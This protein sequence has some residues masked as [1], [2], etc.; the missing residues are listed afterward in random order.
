M[1]KYRI[2]ITSNGADAVFEAAYRSGRFKRLSHIRGKVAPQQWSK[3]MAIIPPIE[4][5]IQILKLEYKGRIEYTEVSVRKTSLFTAMMEKY[6]S[7]YHTSN[8]IPPKIDGTSG[9]HLKAIISYLTSQ[10]STEDECLEVWD[11]ILSGWD[12]L[13][14]FYRSQMELRHINSNLNIILTTLKHGNSNTKT[15]RKA[16]AAANDYRSKF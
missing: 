10:S 3:I 5:G 13:D 11:M 1:N 14:E 16:E 12:N 8:G 2:H 7:W 15:T 4:G 6:A 9:Q